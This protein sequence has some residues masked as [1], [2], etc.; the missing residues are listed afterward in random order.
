[1]ILHRQSVFIPSFD[2]HFCCSEFLLPEGRQWFHAFTI[3]E[4]FESKVK[5]RVNIYLMEA[6]EY[7]CHAW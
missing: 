2:Y 7:V 3:V 4:G 1:M 6:N 5:R